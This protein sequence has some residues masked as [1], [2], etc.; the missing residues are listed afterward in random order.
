MIKFCT[1]QCKSRDRANSANIFKFVGIAHQVQKS[2]PQILSRPFFPLRS[3]PC[4]ACLLACVICYANLFSITCYQRFASD[5]ANVSNLRRTRTLTE[6]HIHTC[7]GI[8]GERGAACDALSP[9]YKWLITVSACRR[10]NAKTLHIFMNISAS[11]FVFL[12]IKKMRENI[13]WKIYFHFH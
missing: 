1:H 11:A 4:P 9:S 13:T 3:A 7:Q 12:G 10:I 8:R 5:Y 6:R 2:P